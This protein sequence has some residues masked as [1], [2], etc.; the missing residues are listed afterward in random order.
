MIIFIFQSSDP[1]SELQQSKLYAKI[2]M[3]SWPRPSNQAFLPSDHCRSY[4]CP[5]TCLV[6]DNYPDYRAVRLSKLSKRALCHFWVNS[7]FVDE[8]FFG[9]EMC[10]TDLVGCLHILHRKICKDRSFGCRSCNRSTFSRRLCDGVLVFA[11]LSLKEFN[12]NNYFYDFLSI[13]MLK[14]YSKLIK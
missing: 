12:N 7:W 14:F 2:Y 3:K 11:F 1:W 6:F 4:G 9:D 10:W 8:V 13:K 5:K